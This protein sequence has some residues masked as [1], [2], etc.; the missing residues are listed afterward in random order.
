MNIKVNFQIHGLHEAGKNQTQIAAQLDISRG[1][2]GYSL[3]RGTVS[4][5]KIKGQLPILKADDVSQIISYIESSPE[6]RR[7]TFL[8]LAHGHLDNLVSVSR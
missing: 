7:Q 6:N 3:R 2:V 4:P 8:E 1:K 5:K